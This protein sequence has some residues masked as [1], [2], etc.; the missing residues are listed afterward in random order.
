MELVS[1][2]SYHLGIS[3]TFDK[4]FEV[5]YLSEWHQG[6]LVLTLWKIRVRNRESE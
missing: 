4:I 1:F 6:K 5:Y 3:T 2:E